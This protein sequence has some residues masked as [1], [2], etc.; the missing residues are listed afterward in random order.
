MFLINCVIIYYII[1]CCI[2]NI[3]DVAS[4]IKCLILVHMGEKLNDNMVDSAET[5]IWD[6]FLSILTCQC[7][8]F[9]EHPITLPCG[10]TVCDK[11]L[12]SSNRCPVDE[13]SF[14]LKERILL[15]ENVIIKGLVEK[16]VPTHLCVRARAKKETTNSHSDLQLRI[17]DKG[18]NV[19]SNFFN[20]K[21]HY[22]HDENSIT[23]RKKK[24]LQD[25]HDI[26]SIQ[27]KID[28]DD[29][30]LQMNENKYV[31]SLPSIE[32]FECPLCMSL[33]IYPTTTECG[34]V[35]CWNC[36]ENSTDHVTVCPQC[37]SPIASNFQFN[38]YL[39]KLN[40][41]SIDEKIKHPYN[42]P[43]TE[44]LHRLI[45]LLF[46]DFYEKQISIMNQKYTVKRI[47]E[48]ILEIP[49]FLCSITFPTLKAPF[50]MMEPH[51]LRMVR[52]SI[53]SQSCIFGVCSQANSSN[54]MNDYSHVGTL[55]QLIKTE[56][57]PSHVVVSTI[58]TRRFKVLEK[59]DDNGLSIATVELFSDVW[60][61]MSELQYSDI[62]KRAKI[63]YKILNNY[64][65]KLTMSEKTVITQA[66]G[67]MPTF[68]PDLKLFPNGIDWLWWS[69]ALLPFNHEK[70][71]SLLGSRSFTERMITVLKFLQIL[72]RAIKPSIKEVSISEPIEQHDTNNIFIP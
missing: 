43:V 67:E 7:L 29:D 32:E 3:I 55:L 53:L 10:H 13:C 68:I 14:N 57:F 34:H 9:L 51:Y 8:S 70:Q 30:K 17:T 71:L 66:I 6:E 59:K 19:V 4:S 20:R 50:R 72:M 38:G 36:V 52:E 23:K 35:L 15:K 60:P 56:H 12:T 69:I 24:I 16:Y 2:I 18:L 39:N 11:C 61:E 31:K 40:I 41:W 46:G 62:I 42:R 48:R 58:A 26:S 33:A 63:V 64:I 47:N 25:Q 49:I 27:V 65:D 44:I 5:D 37:R 1:I 45:H 22:M 21:Y 54:N 28:E